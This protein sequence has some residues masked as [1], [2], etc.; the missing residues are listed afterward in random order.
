M[1]RLLILFIIL[2]SISGYGQDIPKGAN[3]ILITTNLPDSALYK[4]AGQLL[5]AEDFSINYANKDFLQLQ[6]EYKKVKSVNS[7]PRLKITV[8][9]GVA[10]I[11]GTYSR[12]TSGLSGVD[13]GPLS[14]ENRGM[15]LSTVKAAFET[16]ND[17]AV[18]LAQQTGG[19]LRY[20]VKK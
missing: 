3:N 8:A 9:N 6:T 19:Q 17:F 11:N 15:K 7:Y 12:S 10:R 2:I 18:K 13:N 1:K 14:I 4:Q 5:V 20:E 16:M